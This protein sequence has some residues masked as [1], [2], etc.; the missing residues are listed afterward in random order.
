MLRDLNVI[1]GQ[2]KY[3]L[4]TCGLASP[5]LIAFQ[6][7]RLQL[8]ER[9]ELKTRIFSKVRSNSVSILQEVLAH[10][11]SFDV[12]LIVI[13]SLKIHPRTGC[14]NCLQIEYFLF[15]F[16]IV[17]LFYYNFSSCGFHLSRRILKFVLCCGRGL[18]PC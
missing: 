16:L 12:Q 11:L 15:G 10:L 8:L 13:I 1:L 9:S 14:A 4:T 6:E 5:R 2:F 3:E 7:A 18:A 17:F